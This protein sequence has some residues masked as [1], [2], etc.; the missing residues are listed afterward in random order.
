MVSGFLPK[1]LNTTMSP[2]DNGILNYCVRGDL[3]IIRCPVQSISEVFWDCIC[4]DTFLP[5]FEALAY[6]LPYF[7]EPCV[8]SVHL[9]N[10]C[11]GLLFCLRTGIQQFTTEHG[12]LDS[13]A[14]F[15]EEEGGAFSQ[16]E[17]TRKVVFCHILKQRLIV[18]FS[19]KNF[20]QLS[21]P[22]LPPPSC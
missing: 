14:F 10:V 6:V 7:G 17:D 19:W 20:P 9:S 21:L 3:C 22:T 15:W 5:R 13:T 16:L 18:A 4:V 8:L 2:L 11:W 1:P 12:M